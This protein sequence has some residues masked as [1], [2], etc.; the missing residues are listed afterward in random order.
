MERV[1]VPC[2]CIHGAFCFCIPLVRC[3]RRVEMCKRECTS[4]F[5][6]LSCNTG[7]YRKMADNSN[8]QHAGTVN[9]CIELADREIKKIKL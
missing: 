6:V 5:V 9:F 3:G 1:F 4:F 7:G 8:L 2:I